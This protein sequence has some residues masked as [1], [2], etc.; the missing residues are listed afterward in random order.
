MK[1]GHFKN[2]VLSIGPE[3]KN[4]NQGEEYFSELRV[5]SREVRS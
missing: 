4:R 3:I 1:G 5:R 2:V